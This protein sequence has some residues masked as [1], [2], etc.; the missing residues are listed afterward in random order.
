M[1]KAGEVLYGCIGWQP[2]GTLDALCRLGSLQG[3]QAALAG[4]GLAGQI[5][6]SFRGQLAQVSLEYLMSMPEGNRLVRVS[7]FAGRLG[8]P[9]AVH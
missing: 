3:N 1:R 5:P 4:R 6:R 8:Q 2:V 7:R 9:T